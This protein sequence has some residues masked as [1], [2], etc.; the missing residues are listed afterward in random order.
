MNLGFNC[1]PPWRLGLYRVENK[2][3]CYCHIFWQI[4][5]DQPQLWPQI[6]PNLTKFDQKHHI[7]KVFMA[8]MGDFAQ[9]L[10]YKN[11]ESIEIIVILHFYENSTSR[12]YEGG[13]Q[14]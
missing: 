7:F 6:W 3:F 10:C 9:I 4:S 5:L 1:R 11:R 13:S 14:L 2:L 8:I 12:W